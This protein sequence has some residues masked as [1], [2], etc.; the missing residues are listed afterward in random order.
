MHKSFHWI[1]LYHEILVDPKMGK[2]DNLT[3]RRAI[4]LFLI[5]GDYDQGGALPPID[6]IAWTIHTAQ[7]EILTVLLALEQ[8]G[9]ASRD[10]A[11]SWHITNFAKRQGAISNAERVRAFRQRYANRDQAETHPR[12]N[13]TEPRAESASDTDSDSDKDS[14][15]D[16]VCDTHTPA[17]ESQAQV[18]DEHTPGQKY[19]ARAYNSQ[20]TP[21]QL[22]TIAQLEKNHGYYRLTQVIDWAVSSGIPPGRALRAIRTAITTW[23]DHSP[24]KSRAGDSHRTGALEK[25]RERYTD[26][27]NS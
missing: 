21:S 8:I 6:D 15:Q 18:C 14:E 22:I 27:N 20:P 19:F 5:A 26:G 4:E 2:L 16:S 13:V 3:W 1:K 11:G 7:D 25:L 12:A 17:G 23:S 24:P 10:E 9:I